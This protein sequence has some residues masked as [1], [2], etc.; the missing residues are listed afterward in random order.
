[1]PESSKALVLPRSNNTERSH[2]EGPSL[3]HRTLS[4][5]VHDQ[6]TCFF[7]YNFVV[8]DLGLSRGHLDELPTLI[9]CPGNGALVATVTSVGMAALSNT[10]S[11]PQVMVAARQSYAKA[12]RLINAALRDPVESKTDQTLSAILLLGLFE[13]SC[14]VKYFENENV[15]TLNQI[16]T[17]NSEQ[18]MESWTNHIDGAAALLRFRG[19]DQLRT[20]TGFR[21]YMQC[22][23][24]IV[25][26]L[27]PVGS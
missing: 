10:K 12:L 19:S 25:C 11:A 15:L 14:S 9:Q 20:R 5:S 1:M 4:V 21:I 26:L 22:R 7:F 2:S 27:S 16:I 8:V 6:A 18:S 24:Q 23:A 3:S 13:V 17:C